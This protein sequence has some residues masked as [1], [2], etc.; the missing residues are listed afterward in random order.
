MTFTTIGQVAQGVTIP[1]PLPILT[2]KL[3]DHRLGLT[4]N[5]NSP[6]LFKGRKHSVV[7]ATVAGS[8]TF[9]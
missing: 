9:G 7:M 3:A 2:V 6:P 8:Q 4:N 1:S 5:P